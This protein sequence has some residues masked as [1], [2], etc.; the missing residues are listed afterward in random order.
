[1]NFQ[2]NRKYNIKEQVKLL[3]FDYRF[4]TKTV[5]HLVCFGILLFAIIYSNL[6]NVYSE[7]IYEDTNSVEK[8]QFAIV[9]GASVDQNG[10]PSKMLEDRVNKAV[11]LYK[12]GVVQR[13]LISGKDS[14][15]NFSEVEVMKEILLRNNIPDFVII[16]DNKSQRTYDTC[17]RAKK[18]FNLNKAILIT[19][20]FHLPR[21]LYICNSLGVNSVG[22][23]ADSGVYV[24]QRTLSI[25]ENLA[26]I[27]S[28][29]DINILRPNNGLDE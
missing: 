7:K 2:F 27:K 3:N 13:I 18:V 15:V 14:Y 23:P 10:N 26:I 17:Y 20:N 24:D 22:V 1:M 4:I 9:F 21:A 6:V 11:E 16:E 5:L 12:Q 19:Q 8:Q 25:R 28:V 29:L